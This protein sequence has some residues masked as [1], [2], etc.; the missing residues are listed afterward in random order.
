MAEEKFNLSSLLYTDEHDHTKNKSYEVGPE[1]IDTLISKKDEELGQISQLRIAT[2]ENIIA[3]KSRTIEQLQE[4]LKQYTQSSRR[5]Q[6]EQLQRDAS[7]SSEDREVL[8]QKL[9]EKCMEIADLRTQVKCLLS[10]AC[11]DVL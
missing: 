8:R 5:M 9:Q 7:H 1:E 2:L 4:A 11:R 6:K 10:L 3:D